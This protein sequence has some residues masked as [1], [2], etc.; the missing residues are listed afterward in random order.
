MTSLSRHAATFALALPLFAGLPLLASFGPNTAAAAA[1]TAQEPLEN[2][3]TVQAEIL[4][5]AIELAELAD[6]IKADVERDQ[7]YRCILAYDTDNK[8]AR[9]ALGYTKKKNE[10][11]FKKY[12]E[13]KSRAG[14]DELADLS[15]K[16]K[17]AAEALADRV[18]EC[19]P[20][21]SATARH[22]QDRRAEL[23]N[24]AMLDWNNEDLRERAGQK[25]DEEREEWRI[26]E[27]VDAKFDRLLREGLMK[28]LQANS[29][30]GTRAELDPSGQATG[31]AFT[32]VIECPRA[33]VATT[34]TPE[35]AQ[36]VLEIFHQAPDMLTQMFGI[37]DP[38]AQQGVQFRY[39]GLADPDLRLQFYQ[40]HPEFQGDPQ[41]QSTI[42]G[43]QF[44]NY[45]CCIASNQAAGRYDM[46]ANQRVGNY[47]EQVFGADL[48]K[49]WVRAGL[50]LFLSSQ[51][52]GTRLTLWIQT[53]DYGEKDGPSLG[54]RLRDPSVDWL[55]EARLLL[56][57]SSNPVN[58]VTVIGKKTADFS[59]EDLLASYA[60][61]AYLFEGRRADLIEILKG[62]GKGDN[63]TLT[64]EKHLGMP[65]DAFRERL[66]EWL[67]EMRKG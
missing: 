28:D 1:T 37:P 9:K 67:G 16:R 59:A 19:F 66:V 22:K 25:W 49:G 7:I 60:I 55:D 53:D 10:W 65:M 15:A 34:G 51:L 40:R 20:T 62:V 14:D 13:P 48:N 2:L 42:A 11:V 4:A 33:L 6:D 64:F 8:D 29:P 31:I 39:Y 44:G 3:K 58:L 30:T 32:T 5:K 35:E 36:R 41:Y 43:S 26:F 56:R 21:E 45:I 38:F 61:S 24:L 23:A 47:L 63:P 46:A 17:A 54:E 12:K 52:C 50:G 18:D 57:R 27:V